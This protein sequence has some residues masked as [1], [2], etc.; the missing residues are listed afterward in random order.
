MRTLRLLV[1]YDGRHFHGWQRQPT[2]ETV[3]GL[4]STQLERLLREP[5]R[6][7]GASRTDSGVHALGQVASFSTGSALDPLAIRG[8]LNSLLPQA[9][10]VRLVEEA[11][12]GFDA[13]RSAK[14]KRYVYLIEHA[15]V[16]SPILAP[17]SWHIRQPLDLTLMAKAIRPLR[18]KHDFSSFCAAPGRMRNPICR[19]FS[20]H[21][22]RRREVVALFFS[23]DSFLHHMVRN[24]VG[25]LVEIGKR[26]RPPEWM[27]DLLSARDRTQ[28]GPT[29]PAQGL[30]LLRVV[31]PSWA[32]RA[33]A[34][35]MET[36]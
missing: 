24:I 28:A 27:S 6:L 5:I 18:G 21:L 2:Q 35:T 25:S 22:R 29:A 3:Q 12:D 14:A 33:L 32:T 15:Q 8:A 30:T 10:R 4:L 13:R 20:T 34:R 11:P 16:A 19:V 36:K 23:A 31:Y 26:R 17:F 7:I 9:I 1:E